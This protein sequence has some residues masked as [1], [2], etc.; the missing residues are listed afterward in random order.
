MKC[1]KQYSLLL[2]LLI[3]TVVFSLTFSTPA[4]GGVVY[5]STIQFNNT[6]DANNNIF[7]GSV[8]L[9]NVTGGTT[10]GPFALN[11]TGGCSISGIGNGTTYHLKFYWQ[12]TEV[13]QTED[14]TTSANPETANTV[15]PYTL[16]RLVMTVNGS[17]VSF[18]IT[19]ATGVTLISVEYSDKVLRATVNASSGAVSVVKV[20]H[21]TD[22]AS[23]TKVFIGGEDVT[24]YSVTEAELGKYPRCWYYDSANMVVVLKGVHSSSLTY[25]VQFK[26]AS[27]VSWIPIPN[28][29][30]TI[31]IFN[32]TIPTLLL[33]LLVLAIIVVI[34]GA[35]L[36]ISARR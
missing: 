25:E 21:G 18:F 3:L 16:S 8:Y 23:P 6:T 24:A 32:T 4:F 11:S 28:L 10:H 19:N 35:F 1:C 15:G 7:T 22:L 5:D 12:G 34:G 36:L 29:P 26:P 9:V 33:A 2:S 17:S 13:Y 31:T 27:S 14:F 30:Q 20:F